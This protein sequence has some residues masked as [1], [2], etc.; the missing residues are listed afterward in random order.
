MF[1][2]FILF[3]LFGFL[4]FTALAQP[5]SQTSLDCNTPDSFTLGAGGYT[6]CTATNASLNDFDCDGTADVGFSVENSVWFNYCNN[7]GS[8]LTIDFVVDEVDDTENCNVQGALFI[9]TSASA[10]VGNGVVDQYTSNPG[11]AADGFTVTATIP[12]GECAYIVVDGYAGGTCSDL[13]INADC[14][15]LPPVVSAVSSVDPICPG[16][17]STVLTASG[18]DTYVWSPN[19]D[20]S[21]TTGTS[22]TATPTATTTY[23]VTGTTDGCEGTTTVTVN[24]AVPPVPDAGGDQTGCDGDDFIIGADPVIN[25]DDLDYSW[26]NGDNGTINIIGG[27]QDDN[28]QTTVT[29]AITTTYTVTI[30][31]AAGCIGTDDVII[32]ITPPV[33][34]TFDP[35]TPVC[36][37]ATA[38]TLEGTSLN[39]YT[40]A[41]LP[42][43]ST[44]TLGTTTYTFTPDAG[45]CA[46]ITTLDIL[47]T[48]PITPTFDPIA[49]VCQNDPNPTLEGT[50]LNGY[51][52][53]W[54][55]AV[56]TATL[57][58]TT[59][60]FTPDAGQCAT[61]T[62]LDI[63]VTTPIVP[64]FDPIADVCQNDPNP[65]LEGTSL[66]GFTGTWL[67]AV[68]T[69]TL[70]TTTYTFTPDAG[71]CATTATLDIFVTTPIVPTF[72]PITPVCQNDP[73]PTLEGTS[74]NGFSGS[75]L[76]AV[77]TATLGTTTYTF[78]PDA[79][80]CATITTLDI[81]VTTPVT[82]T[83]DP[84]ADV[85][86]NDPNPTLEGT[87]L[88]GFTG[89][90]LPAVSTA[91]LGTTTYTFT[92]D[93][94]QC[95]T[96]ATLDIFVT[97][98]V[99]PTF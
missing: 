70:G 34:P 28:G 92:P 88:N 93:A 77:S 75:W 18:A 89:S 68:S 11:G 1:N 23:T 12:D 22:V 21:S 58:T 65:T 14:P 83:F 64:T 71:Q 98:P 40:G 80:Q 17:G 74:L 62:T 61:T 24:V 53:T 43:V 59:Y 69:A 19:T 87:S 37:N 48:T 63:F 13:T 30:T 50:S 95:A 31:D 2:K 57:G 4:G 7:S 32:T 15:C 33:L 81:L 41:W 76:P 26:S 51:T 42:A 6:G 8:P 36:Q 94:G 56:S 86:Q 79:G 27:G 16:T 44:A 52:G 90:W 35:I 9:G 78:T 45:Q 29:P 85:C 67:P 38:P 96:T 97:T 55:P 46:T 54:L 39:G 3:T 91:T 82:P 20:L 60:T 49:D 84:I 10:A 25:V 73:N 66:N 5:N 72:D 99:V 47:V